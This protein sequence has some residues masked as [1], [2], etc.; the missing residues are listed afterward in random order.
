MGRIFTSIDRFLIFVISFAF[1]GIIYGIILFSINAYYLY[2][3]QLA[4]DPNLDNAKIRSGV[5]L[6]GLLAALFFIL[7]ILNIAAIQIYVTDVNGGPA[8]G[9]AEI[10]NVGG[11]G[12]PFQKLQQILQLNK[13]K[14][15]TQ[16]VDKN[17]G[18]LLNRERKIVKWTPPNEQGESYFVVDGCSNV[19]GQIGGLSAEGIFVRRLNPVDFANTEVV[20]NNLNPNNGLV[21]GISPNAKTEIIPNDATIKVFLGG[22]FQPAKVQSLGV[23]GNEE[24]LVV[25][26]TEIERQA[27]LPKPVELPTFARNPAE[28]IQGQ[29]VSVNVPGVGYTIPGSTTSSAGGGSGTPV[30]A[31]STPIYSA[32]L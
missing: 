21:M 16:V 27:R 22:K 24:K 5:A 2:E 15:S 1:F 8:K 4:N 20:Y 28:S 30:V 18:R 7:F 12:P 17:T 23:C 3:L 32:S 25:P 29:G 31:S 19:P 13:G 14:M 26:L 9:K 10:Q 6:N 11:L